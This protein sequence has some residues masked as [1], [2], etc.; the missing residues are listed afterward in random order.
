EM[1]EA[2]KK[3]TEEG[4]EAAVEYWWGSA[5]YLKSTG[6]PDP[7]GRVSGDGCELCQRQVEIWDWV[8][9]EGGWAMADDAQVNEPIAR[10]EDDRTNGSFVTQVTESSIQV[11]KPD[12]S[13]AD[14]ASAMEESESNW[15]G[16]AVFDAEAKAWKITAMEVLG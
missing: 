13:I 8:Y 11:Y 10:V 6:D 14:E 4:L 2:V 1:P 9:Q 7:L 16:T 3:P 12:G 15:S 5:S